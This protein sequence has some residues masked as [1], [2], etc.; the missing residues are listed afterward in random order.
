MTKRLC[1][2]HPRANEHLNKLALEYYVA[3]RA[4][5]MCRGGFITGNLIHHA[6]ELLLKDELSKTVSLGA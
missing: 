5:L 4:S 1:V 2:A 3:A 6:V